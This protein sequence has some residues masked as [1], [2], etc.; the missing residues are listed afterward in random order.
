MPTKLSNFF[1][2][3]GCLSPIIG[4]TILIYLLVHESLL[5]GLIYLGVF[6]VIMII[7]FV[8]ASQLED[9]RKAK[10][11]HLLSALQPKDEDYYETQ[12]YVAYDILS[13]I[14]VDAKNERIYFWAPENPEIYT[15]KDA[16]YGMPYQIFSYPYSA[17]LSVQ[18]IEDS[19][20]VS[21]KSR[22]SKSARVLL[23]GLEPTNDTP[24]EKPSS[25]ERINS[26]ALKLILK[27]QVRPIHVVPFYTDSNSSL[28]KDSPEYRRAKNEIEQWFTILHFI[29]KDTDQ[30]EGYIYA[31]ET[32]IE[33]P[34]FISDA[35]EKR[36]Q[37]P[38]YDEHKALVKTQLLSVLNQVIYKKI[39]EYGAVKT[40]VSPQPRENATSYF[41]E[42]LQKNR[43]QL[44]GNNIDE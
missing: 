9:K 17:L 21:T 15:I 25:N 2:G 30:K 40:D 13:R 26:M 23:D 16:F 38:V 36:I 6:I 20:T 32:E 44:H 27:D 34:Q 12:S 18:I 35:E 29:I 11:K 10:Q 28:N 3:L 14:A 4:V 19:A 37:Y 22:Q 41:D 8:I 42:L 24:P 7:L 43:K 1:L 39:V 31:Q 33:Q 5:S